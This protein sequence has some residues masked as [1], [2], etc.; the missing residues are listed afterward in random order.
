MFP[1]EFCKISI[2]TF[3][4]E[5]PRTTTSADS[6]TSGTLVAQRHSK[7]SDIDHDE[8]FAPLVNYNWIPFL[9]AVSNELDLEIHQMN[10]K[11]AFLNSELNEKI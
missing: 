4:T 7:N 2:D 1:C 3:F 6:T 9:L 8:L 11:T 10:T 5:H